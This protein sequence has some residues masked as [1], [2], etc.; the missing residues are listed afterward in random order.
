MMK[1][2]F[3]LL[4]ALFVMG[5]NGFSSGSVQAS[6]TPGEVIGPEAP[7]W[8]K[9]HEAFSAGMTANDGYVYENTA[10][11][12]GAP[13]QMVAGPMYSDD[14]PAPT[15]AGPPPVPAPATYISAAIALLGLGLCGRRL[16][17]QSRSS[18][19]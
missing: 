14:G 13:A 9:T 3:H 18:R 15:P 10:Q 2:T 7:E 6:T 17:R 8:A 4:F 5:G 19:R 1:R 12:A 16:I 11:G